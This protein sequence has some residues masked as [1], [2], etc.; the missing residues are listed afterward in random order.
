MK[1]LA[2]THVGA[3]NKLRSFAADRLFVAISTNYCSSIFDLIAKK[4]EQSEK[5]PK[6]GS[7]LQN[8]KA[9]GDDDPPQG[10]VTKWRTHPNGV[11]IRISR[12]A[13]GE[14]LL[15]EGTPVTG[16]ASSILDSHEKWEKGTLKE[17]PNLEDI[18]MGEEPLH[19]NKGYLLKYIR[20]LQPNDS[21]KRY[22]LATKYVVKNV[23]RFHENELLFILK[24]FA[25]RKYKNLPLLQCTSEYFYWQCKMNKGSQRSISHYLHLC[26]LL[27]YVP[28]REYI[29]TYITLFNYCKGEERKDSSFLFF[30]LIEEEINERHKDL[31]HIILVL[32]FLHKGKI[33]NETFDVLLHMCCHYACHLSLRDTFLLLRVIL[34]EESWRNNSDCI[35]D[36]HRNVER[37]FEK[38]T[39][40]DFTSYV[41]MLLHN[42]VPLEQTFFLFIRKFMHKH[43]E[44]LSPS[45]VLSILK[46]LKREKFKETT[47][48]KEAL[49]VIRSNFFHY[50]YADV[51]YV[52][53]MLTLLN[54]FEE[55]FF[56]FLLEK[57]VPFGGALP[58]GGLVP[59][60]GG[61]P[62]TC[63]AVHTG[64]DGERPS[65]G[66][67]HWSAVGR[68]HLQKVEE[69][70]EWDERD[71]RHLLVS[72]VHR[73]AQVPQ[74][75]GPIHE[76]SHLP[77]HLH[78]QR[79][80]MKLEVCNIVGGEEPV[81]RDTQMGEVPFGVQYLEMYLSLFVYLGTC[82][83]RASDAL[84]RL[85]Q[86][87][88]QC[89]IKGGGSGDGSSGSD[90]S[91]SANATQQANRFHINLLKRGEPRFVC[92][93]DA[94][95]EVKKGAN[96][97]LFPLDRRTPV[98]QSAGQSCSP[99]QHKP[100]KKSKADV[101][102]HSSAHHPAATPTGGNKSC[103]RFSYKES[104]KI[105]LESLKK[106]KKKKTIHGGDRSQDKKD[107]SDWK[108]L[109][110]EMFRKAKRLHLS[111]D[112]KGGGQTGERGCYETTGRGKRDS[113]VA[114]YFGDVHPAAIRLHNRRL[115]RRHFDELHPS[116]RYTEKAPPKVRPKSGPKSGRDLRLTRYKQIR[117]LRNVCLRRYAQLFR[118]ASDEAL[119]GVEWGSKT[120]A[121]SG[122]D[123][124]CSPGKAYEQTYELPHEELCELPY[125]PPLDML[126]DGKL[127]HVDDALLVDYTRCENKGKVALRKHSRLVRKSNQLTRKEYAKSGD[128]VEEQNWGEDNPSGELVKWLYRYKNCLSLFPDGRK[129]EI[130]LLDGDIKQL[131]ECMQKWY[132]QSVT[133]K[134]RITEKER[135]KGKAQISLKH[136]ALMTNVCSSLYHFDEALIDVILSQV[137]KVLRWF[138]TRQ[139]WEE[140]KRMESQELQ[141]CP[142]VR[143]TYQCMCRFTN[144]WKFITVCL[145]INRF[146]QNVLSLDHRHGTVTKLVHLYGNPYTLLN[147]NHLTCVMNQVEGL[148]QQVERPSLMKR[149][150]LQYLDISAVTNMYFFFCKNLFIL[151]M[152]GWGNLMEDDLQLLLTFTY[153]MLTL[154]RDY[155]RQWIAHSDGL[156]PSPF[157]GMAR[158]GSIEDTT[159]LRCV[160]FFVVFVCAA[161]PGWGGKTRGASPRLGEGDWSVGR[162]ER[163]GQSERSCEAVRGDVPPEAAHRVDML[164]ILAL[165]LRYV[166]LFIRARDFPPP[167]RGKREDPTRMHL[168][169]QTGMSTHTKARTNAQGQLLPALQFYYLLRR[170]VR[171]RNPTEINEL[172]FPEVFPAF[173]TKWLNQE[174]VKEMPMRE[175]FPVGRLQRWSVERSPLSDSSTP[176]SHVDTTLCQHFFNF[177][178]V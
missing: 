84:L 23:S 78:E 101:R 69:R 137:T 10:D 140:K 166:K 103:L 133:K 130:H 13:K 161:Y 144:V 96:F 61:R 112:Q 70:D 146:V 170:T 164:A 95:K 100:Q 175:L 115:F 73:F 71:E 37:H 167:V 109:N 56:S 163:V 117:N 67:P 142:S 118:G 4:K 162:S 16:E 32:S 34:T 38:I 45:A 6:K 18:P 24:I 104:E 7:C 98:K 120:G 105:N 22:R 114:K 129:S 82:G 92:L 128:P 20:Q 3:A 106:K 111:G 1:H 58:I 110:V 165:S 43:G 89:L 122:E 27:N 17:L 11:N 113:A 171:K 66:H 51:V 147:L 127:I 49:H 42:H 39:Q 76:L 168:G 108:Y 121:A 74:K 30:N 86:L 88:R 60:C 79:V 90:G 25:K 173:I 26:G 54:H 132:Q 107:V 48:L 44:G 14:K 119:E 153:S 172:T 148:S 176:S 126:A 83:Q 41:K 2:T 53:K 50:T 91:G 97:A 33:K 21:I 169:R 59:T 102:Q 152:S 5:R 65:R 8:G 154:Q 19:N 138:Y 47:I 156:G 157:G 150:L 81:A 123:G 52:V 93:H 116:E 40:G 28:T 149:F 75:K 64:D 125:E 174:G 57:F 141:R 29:K 68:A 72:P 136:M 151:V 46:L 155:A 87:I 31:K 62:S 124:T 94:I 80:R 143:E 139:K 77:L 160:N 15:Q 9:S 134:E 63:K 145:Q 12:A 35:K 159:F 135:G 178:F 85:S 131:G 177:F 36:L 55:S 99:P 158:R